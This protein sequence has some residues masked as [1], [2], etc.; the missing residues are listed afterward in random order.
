V[1]ETL[2]RIISGEYKEPGR[3]ILSHEGI[4]FLRSLLELVRFFSPFFCQ[5]WRDVW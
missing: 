4:L 3:E 5:H 2:Q 1:K